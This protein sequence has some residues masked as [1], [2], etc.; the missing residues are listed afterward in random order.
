MF[1]GIRQFDPPPWLADHPAAT[2]SELIGVRENR[3]D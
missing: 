3:P 2:A 1:R